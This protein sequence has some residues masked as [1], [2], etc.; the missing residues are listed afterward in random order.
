MA[1]YR[2]KPVVID[3]F[4]FYVDNMPDWFFNK[5]G[6]DDIV[7]MNCDYKKFSIKQAYCRIHTLEG[8]MVANGGDYIVQGIDGEIYPVKKEIFEKTYER[9]EE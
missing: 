8:T 6:T 1:K 2:K 3:A 4:R 5:V 9:V 7:L